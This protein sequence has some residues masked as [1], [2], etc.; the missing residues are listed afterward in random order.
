MG[1]L[2][3]TPDSFSDG[4]VN[5]AVDQAFEN[6]QAMI[7]AGAAIVDVGGEST[8]PGSEPV[9]TEDEIARVVPIISRLATTKVAVSID[10]SK[11]E[12]AEDAL[13]AGATMLN[14]IFG[15]RKHESMAA[16][17]AKFGVP[18]VVMHIQGEPK[19]MQAAPTYDDV[20]KEVI[21]SLW[22]SVRIGTAAG[23]RPQDII[24]D[25]GIGFGKTFEHN[26][27][28]L[29]SLPELV[30]EFGRHGHGMLLGA[31]RKSFLGQLLGGNRPPLE[32]DIA[33]TAV[34]SFAARAG[35]SIIRV[36]NVQANADVLAVDRWLA[37]A[38]E[39]VG[40]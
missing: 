27:R 30:Q 25:P 18:A 5:L 33:T 22:E 37:G 40:A 17:A 11:P 31:S 4:G 10:T 15:F 3:V 26:R 24:V 34:T 20:V 16:I 1:V 35:V 38:S 7:A 19:T 32:R 39:K 28:L 36:H 12:V 23:L 13:E 14:D 6:A 21:D 9:D 8:R 2:N 29:Q